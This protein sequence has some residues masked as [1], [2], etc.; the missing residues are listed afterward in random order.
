MPSKPR[1]S[2]P[3]RTVIAAFAGWNDAGSAATEAVSFMADSWGAKLVA[4]IDPEDYYD[5]QVMRPRFQVVGGHRSLEWPRTRVFKAKA[6]GGRKLL[7]VDGIEPSMRWGQFSAELIA[8]LLDKG[9]GSLIVLGALLADVPHT[10]AIPVSA[11]SSDPGV[12][13]EFG[14]EASEYTGPTGIVG[15]LEHL[16]GELSDLPS[17]SL[18]AAVPHYVANPPSPKATLAILARIEELL[19]ISIDTEDLP[20]EA[21]AWQEGVDELSAED[22]DI[23][24]YVKQLEAAKDAADSPEA[25]GEAIAKEFERYLQRRDS[26]GKPGL[27]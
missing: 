11:S 9:A 3:N 12:R 19:G 15:V 2:L 5:F 26:G 7:L 1:Q 23:A 17:L 14:L 21:R 6:P 22:S 4:E 24:E 20:E 27:A 10:R 18:W 8:T 25:S 16:A 13:E